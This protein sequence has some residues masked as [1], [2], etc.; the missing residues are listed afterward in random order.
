MTVVVGG[1]ALVS[2]GLY[3]GGKAFIDAFSDKAGKELGERAADKLLGHPKPA[4]SSN[5]RKK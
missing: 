5:E 1:V 4:V 3:K 2:S